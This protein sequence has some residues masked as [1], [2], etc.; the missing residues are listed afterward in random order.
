MR[1][2]ILTHAHLEV[3]GLDLACGIVLMPAFA[4]HTTSAAGTGVSENRRRSLSVSW[5]VFAIVM[6]TR[7]VHSTGFEMSHFR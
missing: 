5:R 3:S 4:T 7:H 6:R 1:V 2:T